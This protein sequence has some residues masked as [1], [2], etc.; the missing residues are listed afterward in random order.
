MPE[1]PT[2]KNVVA[3]VQAANPQVQNAEEEGYGDEESGED[4]D[5]RREDDK[6]DGSSTIES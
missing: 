4:A 1:T 2:G 5:Y 6:V 3:K